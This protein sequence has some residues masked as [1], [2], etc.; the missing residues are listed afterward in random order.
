[1]LRILFFLC[2]L[3]LI[4]ATLNAQIEILGDESF[5][6]QVQKCLEEGKVVSAHIK[7]LIETAENAAVVIKIRPI[8]DDPATFHK[9]A[10]KDAKCR[11]VPSDKAKP[12]LARS[13]PTG[14]TIYLRGGSV[15]PGNKAY[16][17]GNTMHELALAVDLA[18]GHY[19]AD[20]N[21]REKRAVF[22][23]NIWRDAH[24]KSLRNRFSGTCTTEEYAKA[25]AN[26]QIDQFVAHYF[27]ENDLPD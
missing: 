8:S 7:R 18:T 23:Q 2:S 14:A 24:D 12:D 10:K 3:T 20:Q 21:I 1:M 5:K 13:E 15:D 9:R 16:N 26:G 25:K 22:F 11:T 19:H 6:I 27:S 4:P 17:K